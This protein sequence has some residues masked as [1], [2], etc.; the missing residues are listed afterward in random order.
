[1]STLSLKEKKCV[2]RTIKAH[3]KRLYPERGGGNRLAKDLN[4]SP[5]LLSQW[6]NGTRFPT[7]ERLIAL[8]EFFG[9]T[10]Q[11][12]CGREKPAVIDAEVNFYDAV[13]ILTKHLNKKR[14]GKK[15]NKSLKTVKRFME[16]TLEDFP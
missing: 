8:A 15:T 4:V 5:Q 7:T 13:M 2:V 3:K 11:E 6:I 9:V 14:S 12:L 10:I 1:M 16:K